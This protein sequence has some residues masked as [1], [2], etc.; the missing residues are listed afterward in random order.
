MAKEKQNRVPYTT[1]WEPKSLAA[2]KAAAAHA[3]RQSMQ[4]F[5]QEA[6]V[7]AA[8]RKVG[9]V[10]K[11]GELAMLISL[12]TRMRD[13]ATKRNNTP[14]VDAV[15]ATIAKLESMI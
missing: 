13:D 1:R 4:D 3:P 14:V 7:T 2:V 12:A 11:Y 6:A 9:V 8:E 5:L 10:L 15:N